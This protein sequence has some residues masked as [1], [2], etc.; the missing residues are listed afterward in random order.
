MS[1][2]GGSAAPIEL[3]GVGIRYGRETVLRDVS[4]VAG[5]GR[6]FALL[7]RNGSGKSSLVRCLLG[8][9]R[10]S[11]GSLRVLGLDSWR[12]R[13]EL[14]RRVGVVPEN[15]DAPPELSA[16]RLAGFCRS[17]H[18]QWDAAG[19][20]ARLDRLGVPPDR[21]FGRLS[22]GQKGAV[23]LS[24]ALGHGPELLVLDDPTLGL[25]VVARDEIFRDVIG[26]LA[27]R[28]T[29]VFLTTH[30]LRSVEGVADDVGILSGGGLVVSDALESLKTRWSRSL[31]EIFTAVARGEREPVPQGVSA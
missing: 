13:V 1:H 15:P 31:E 17:L 8:A 29:T 6:V 4:L 5:Q 23:M 25:D 7:G 3:D 9:Q 14:V 10:V 26:E 18:A 12:D 11:A 22:K 30:D 20:M 24:L 21:P 2:H 19:V 16:R 27:D 28:G